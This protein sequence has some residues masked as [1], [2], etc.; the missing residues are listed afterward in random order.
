MYKFILHIQHEK[1]EKKIHLYAKEQQEKQ[2]I[3]TNHI[4]LIQKEVKTKS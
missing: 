3:R 1:K 4:S 2:F